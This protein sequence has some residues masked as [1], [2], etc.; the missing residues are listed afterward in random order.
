M[1]FLGK[2][3]IVTGGA[4]GIGKAIVEGI[5]SRNGHAIIL[6]LNSEAGEAVKVELGKDKVSF[7]KVNLGDSHE[8]RVVLA[9]ILNDFGQIHGLINNAGIISALPF[10]KITQEEWDKVIAINLTANYTTISALYPSMK[11]H[12]YGRIVNVASIAA[13]RGG[14]FLG[15]SAYAASKAGVIGLT[16]AVAREGAPHGIVC[17]AVCPGPTMTSM[18]IDNVDEEKMVKILATVPMGRGG[19]PQEIADVVLF[20]L[21]DLASFVTGEI[22]NVDG[23]AT[24]D[25]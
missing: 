16:K 17:N 25:G 5:V 20:Y 8:I 19:K 15:T 14:G 13:K 23:G 11:E 21:S 24:M 12:G 3:I 9:K 18:I 2:N 10:E 7:Y 6:D 4:S 22:T 1:E